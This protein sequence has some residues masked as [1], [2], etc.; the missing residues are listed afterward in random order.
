MAQGRT[1]RCFAGA[2]W[3]LLRLGSIIE[4]QQCR[5]EQAQDGEAQAEAA[6]HAAK[7]G[8]SRGTTPGK[9]LFV[10]IIQR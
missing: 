4:E 10:P 2:G 9:P 5:D 3:P 7:V 1:R 8:S 6:G